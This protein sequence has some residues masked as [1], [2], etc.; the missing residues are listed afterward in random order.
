MG[1]SIKFSGLASGLDTESLVNAL[2]TPYQSKVD[3]SKQTSDLYSMKKD[4]WKEINTKVSS[5]FTGT[6]NNMRL[7]GNYNKSSISTSVDG[8]VKTSTGSLPTGSHTI[9]VTSL[10]ESANLE[11]SRIRLTSGGKVTK[12]TTLNELGIDFTNGP[13]KLEV[14]EGANITTVTLTE[15]MKISDV[16]SAFKTALPNT[17]VSF[18]TSLGAFS[19]SSKETGESQSIKL[20]I[21][22]GDQG[23]LSALGFSVK[24]ETDSQG[25]TRNVASAKG[26]NTVATYNGMNIDSESN[27][28]ELNGA[29][30][31]LVGT[32]T[33][34]LS[35]NANT[36]DVYTMI[37][38]FVDEYNKLLDE[39]NTLVYAEA[40]NSYDP[41]TDAQKEEMSEK[42]IELW[43]ERINK[44][45]LRN[46]PTLK[47]ITTIMRQS[48]S[49]AKVQIGTND[50][51]EPVYM[52]MASIGIS[53]SSNWTEK[54]KLHIDE[55]KL[56]A[57]LEENSEAVTQ[58]FAGK[59]DAATGKQDG[60]M[61]TLY[62]KLNDKFKAVPN[63][64]SSNFLFNDKTLDNKI[65]EQ[66]KQTDKLIDKMEAME[67][68]YYA[69]F[70][71]ME[72][73]LTSLNSQ[74]SYFSSMLG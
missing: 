28:V 67:D 44:S 31:T 50:K 57:A 40:N 4:A 29:K 38:T 33:T 73:M 17:N 48:I 47:E 55:K 65:K 26:K 13:V 5:F 49:D 27:E 39:I 64:K 7:E 62:S 54:G 63:Q 59:A 37:T 53:T 11:T 15:N 74:S 18:N 8:I 56:K 66:N 72:K 24:S 43:N 21:N 3:Q 16:E 70:T 61:T 58:L 68:L 22:A 25:V 36:D 23:A 6:L 42:E 30:V 19:I 32:G 9:K 60:A 41:L 35:S 69:R 52:T 46:D 20:A 14:G 45:I 34:T 1:T 2:I 51:G 10:A 71:A 12:D